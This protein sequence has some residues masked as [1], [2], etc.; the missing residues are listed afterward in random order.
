MQV[1]GNLKSNLQ[2]IC[3]KIN[4][5]GFMNV[6]DLIR[7]TVVAKTH[8]QIIQAYEILNSHE[9]LTILRVKNKL[10]EPLQL[11]HLN[12]AYKG[13]MIGEV[14]IKIG[15]TPVQYASNHFLYELVRADSVEQLRQ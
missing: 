2:R 13:R 1:S 4:E 12:V 5:D 11:V 7:A 14:Q 10:R 15:I 9:H 6:Q 8:D 3:Q